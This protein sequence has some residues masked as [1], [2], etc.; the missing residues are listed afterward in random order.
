[1][2]YIIPLVLIYLRTVY[3][4]TFFLQFLLPPTLITTSLISMNLVVF[5]LFFFFPWDSTYKWSDIVFVLLW[6]I[7]PSITPSRSTNL[8]YP[9]FLC[10]QFRFPDIVWT[11]EYIKLTLSSCVLFSW[12]RHF[13][14][15]FHR[16]VAQRAQ[17]YHSDFWKYRNWSSLCQNVFEKLKEW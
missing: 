1:M 5:C 9:I 6:L 17:L 4:L 2:L 8:I 3:L 11:R 10:N 16:T 13:G 15:G 7:S 14:S 12:T